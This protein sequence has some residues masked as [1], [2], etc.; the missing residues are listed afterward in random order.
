MAGL[1]YPIN[2]EKFGDS[3]AGSRV[4]GASHSENSETKWMFRMG[5]EKVWCSQSLGAETGTENDPPLYSSRIINNYV[6]YLQEYH[7]NIEIKSILEYAG[8]AEQEVEDAGHWF[9]Q[10]LT[11]RFHEIIVAKTGNPHISREAGRFSI[12]CKRI[13]AAKQYALGFLNPTAIYLRIG[14]IAKTISRG[15]VI[16]GKKL[17]GTKVEIV[18]IPS[19]GTNEKLYQCENRIGFMEA[20]AKIFTNKFAEIDHPSCFHKGDDCCRYIVTWEKTPAI[21]W[22]QIRN[23]MLF[24]GLTTSLVL[25]PILSRESWLVLVLTSFFC[26]WQHSST[27]NGSKKRTYKNH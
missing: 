15:T 10:L 14:K 13:G 21:I 12:S 20:A 19:P 3:K 1:I 23:A 7:P 26:I 24:S 4:V 9:S 5:T 25:S 16:S 8:M 2:E 22:K 17:G 27:L 6:E 18:S 11:D